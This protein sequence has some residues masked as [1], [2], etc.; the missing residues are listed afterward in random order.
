MKVLPTFASPGA[1]YRLSVA[2]RVLAAVVGGYA[3][4]S[5]LNIALPL[6][7]EKA[8]ANLPQALLWTMMASFLVWAAIIIGVFSIRSA[9][10]AWSWL[11]GSAVPLGLIVWLLLPSAAV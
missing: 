10:R 11:A 3:L 1:R 4:T 2:S 8:G 7:L 5:L 6:L 9:A